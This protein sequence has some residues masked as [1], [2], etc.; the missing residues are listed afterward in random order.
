MPAPEGAQ[1]SE[2]GNYWWDTSANEW[3][4]VADT[5]A[6]AASSAG[7]ATG[8]SDTPADTQQEGQLSPDGN[9]RWDGSQWQPVEATPADGAAGTEG[10]AAGAAAGDGQVVI[11]DDLQ[12][13]LVGWK[14]SF[15]ELAT[16]MDTG[17]HDTYLAQVV[18]ITPGPDDNAVA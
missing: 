15:P 8:S 7:A 1:L 16:L 9:Y 14:S 4:S 18:G 3:K 5:P 17:D 10:G 2:D 12:Q 13:E 6:D 11:P